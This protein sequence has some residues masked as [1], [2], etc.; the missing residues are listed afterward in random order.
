VRRFNDDYA[1]AY[2]DRGVEPDRGYR[3]RRG[4]EE[5][6]F[7]AGPRRLLDPNAG[8]AAAAGSAAVRP[9]G[10]GP[11]PAAPV[12]GRSEEAADINQTLADPA[13][14]EAR[15]RAAAEPRGGDPA[16][17]AAAAAADAHF[18]APPE[19]R[20][21]RV[22]DARGMDDA[23]GI[24]PRELDA[25]VRIDEGGTVDAD[26]PVGG[27]RYDS[28]GAPAHSYGQPADAYGPEYGDGRIGFDHVSRGPYGADDAAP[29][30]AGEP[31]LVRYRTYEDGYRGPSGR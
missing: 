5:L 14:A 4:E 25:R 2:G 1:R 18:A 6:R 20:G 16:L 7:A 3:V 22:E 23:Q 13:A 12:A 11:A 15:R 26:A 8:L 9:A 24:D 31:R 28:P 29:D 21:D 17:L 19:R 10:P 30:A 27:V